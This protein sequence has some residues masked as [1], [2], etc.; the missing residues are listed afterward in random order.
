MLLDTRTNMQYTTAMSTREYIVQ[1]IDISAQ[2]GALGMSLDDHIVVHMALKSLP[3][4]FN[5]LKTTYNTLKEKL[6][7]LEWT[8]CSLCARGG[9][10]QERQRS[11]CQLNWSLRHRGKKWKFGNSASTSKTNYHHAQKKPMGVKGK[12]NFKCFFCK[13][14]GYM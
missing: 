5:Q 11:H 6:I 1:M 12:G 7:V 3:A 13:K 8:H 4:H 9:E 2:L 10:E 14:E